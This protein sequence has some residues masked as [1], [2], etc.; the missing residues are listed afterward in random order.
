MQEK[1]KPEGKRNIRLAKKSLRPIGA[2]IENGGQNND[3]MSPS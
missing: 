3:Y 2:I 1:L